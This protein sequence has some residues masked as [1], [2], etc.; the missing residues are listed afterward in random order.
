MT[1]RIEP[2]FGQIYL[3]FRDFFALEVSSDKSDKLQR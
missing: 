3:Q 2:G 1:E